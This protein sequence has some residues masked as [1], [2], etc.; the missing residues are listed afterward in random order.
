MSASG[1]C[2]T[3]VF[4]KQQGFC[5]FPMVLGHE[6]AGIVESVGHS[7]SHIKPGD[8]VVMTYASCGSCNA[9]H[10][11]KPAYCSSHG[12]LN[13]GAA[14]PDGTTPFL[15]SGSLISA[16]RYYCQLFIATTAIQITLR[17][18]SVATSSSK[19]LLLLMRSP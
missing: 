6:G 1:I 11:A 12:P 14:S 17:R 10:K 8:H 3:D 7:I 19:V 2:H 18:R 9:C 5:P 13:F 15:S 16:F 4:T